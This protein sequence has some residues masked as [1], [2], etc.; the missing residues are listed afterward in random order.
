[1]VSAASPSRWARVGARLG[2]VLL[3]LP[4]VAVLAAMLG[5]PIYSLVR[6]SLQ[7]YTLFELI[8]HHGQW[9]GLDN[10]SLGP[11]RPGLLAHAAPDGR[12]SRSRTSA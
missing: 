11:A 4:V 7:H 5:Y 1:M 2:S 10:F 6:L 12:S 8:R 9:V 3:I